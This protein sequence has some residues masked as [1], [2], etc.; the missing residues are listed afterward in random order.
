[1]ESPLVVRFA[2]FAL[3]RSSQTLK[4]DGENVKIRPKAFA[5]LDFLVRHPDKVLGKS[6]IFDSVWPDRIVTE[7]G[8]SELIRELR[9]ALEDDARAPKFIETVHG[10]G[11]RFIGADP[12]VSDIQEQSPSDTRNFTPPI[13]RGDELALLIERFDECRHGRRR[14]LFV[15]GE[16]GIGKTTLVD[17]FVDYARS[18]R[19]SPR[20]LQGQCI[21]HYGSGEGYL[22]L[23]D[24]LGRALRRGDAALAQEIRRTAPSWIMQLPGVLPSDDDDA[25]RMRTAGATQE[26]MLR[27]IALT[28]EHLAREEPLI[29]VLED[30]HWSDYSTLDLLSMM[31]H[32]AE[33][34]Q[35][36]IV[37]TFRPVEV[38][39][40]NHPLKGIKQELELHGLCEELSLP[41][42]SEA[43]VAE[44]LELRLRD[45]RGAPR[46]ATLAPFVYRRTDGHPLFMANV[47]DFVV[48]SAFV[49]VPE[50]IDKTIPDS[51]RLMIEKQIDRLDDAEQQVLEAASVAGVRFA[52]ASIVAATA[53]DADTVERICA[54]LVRRRSF[55]GDVGGVEW[56]DGTYSSGFAFN[57]ALYQNVLYSRVPPGRRARL[58]KAIALREEAGWGVRSDEISA[59]LAAHFQAAK[60]Y[61]KTLQYLVVAG[62]RAAT[63]CANREAIDL[64]NRGLSIL[65]SR[66]P[67]DEHEK[68]ELRFNIALGVP[69]VQSRGYAAEEV[70]AI[71]SRARELCNEVGDPGSL[72]SALWGLWL[73]YVVRAEH[74]TALD[75][76]H[77]LQSLTRDRCPAFPLAD[78]ATGGSE[79]W[80]GDLTASCSNLRAAI[81][82]YDFRV[83]SGEA[84]TYSQDPKV[85]ALSYLGWAL[86]IQGFVDTALE[87]TCEAVDLAEQ[88]A[89][90]FTLAF[91]HSFHA[92]IRVK[93]GETTDAIRHCERALSLSDEHGFPLWQGWSRMILG[94]AVAGARGDESGLE[95]TLSGIEQYRETGASMGSTYFLSLAAEACAILGNPETGD[96][97]TS[98]AIDFGQAKG[99]ILYG[100][101]LVELKFRLACS[102]VGGSITNAWFDNAD[103]ELQRA[104]EHAMTMGARSWQLRVAA[105]RAELA[106]RFCYRS[107][108][109]AAF[110]AAFDALPEGDE[111]TRRAVFAYAPYRT[112]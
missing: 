102:Q 19:G 90:P 1:M 30:L 8:L 103:R 2:P 40:N 75:L 10:R 89:H 5:L 101:A 23:L 70:L 107:D 31:G 16:P 34:A 59:E 7:G 79:F 47:V 60:D 87:I 74:R 35:L 4:R 100:P 106:N 108:G 56:P 71:Y 28:F 46:A 78:Y 25:F 76:G 37:A 15:T 73:Y 104:Y 39:S 83:H 91:A 45:E 61:R 93:R 99:E 24:A 67:D 111:A 44:Y 13:G 33:P 96:A 65:K 64:L 69:L 29:L 109:D 11:Y 77:R 55:L 54:D 43:A 72:L 48:N 38:Y 88:L 20:V 105:L 52:V 22:P 86:W 94:R 3:D 92:G 9:K 26:R 62:E 17:A 21:E 97:I 27:E 84:S 50:S 58:H 95:T 80:C 81:D 53:L 57:H 36:L 49:D 6:E 66:A 41:G 12:V 98:E 85:V 14:I 63:K 32:R 42:L 18:F 68:L 112:T 82:A 110:R 51:V